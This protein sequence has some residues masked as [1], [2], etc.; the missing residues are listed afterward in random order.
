MLN[1][2]HHFVYLQLFLSLSAWARMALNKPQFSELSVWQIPPDRD[3]CWSAGLPYMLHGTDTCE[4]SF[5]ITEAILNKCWRIT[6]F[7]NEVG[8]AQSWTLLPEQGKIT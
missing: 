6:N 5:L 3:D 7:L 8:S 4:V 2:T 1:K